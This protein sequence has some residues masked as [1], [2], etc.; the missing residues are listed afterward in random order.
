[1][2]FTL[3]ER[4]ALIQG[5][6]DYEGLEARVRLSVPFGYDFELRRR[7]RPAETYELLELLKE[8]AADADSANTDRQKEI[9][10]VEAE[11][12]QKQRE[13]IRDWADD[14]LLSWNV[15]DAKGQP[16]PANPEG[17]LEAGQEVALLVI[18]GWREA[19]ISP[20]LP[21]GG[22]PVNGHGPAPASRQKS[23]R[24]RS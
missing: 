6:G 11:I 8:A 22:P 10:R 16:I 4:T 15:Q 14:V 9:D 21:S 5:E 18:K 23:T 1:M 7:L 3:P 2:G 20:P 13:A 12:Q 24:R 19:L 17:V